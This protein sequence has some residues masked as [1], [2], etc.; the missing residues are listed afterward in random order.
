M[1]YEEARNDLLR[2]INDDHRLLFKNLNKIPKERW[3][4]PAINNWSIKDHLAQVLERQNMVK[5]WYDTGNTGEIPEIPM[6]GYKWNQ[7]DEIYEM[8]YQRYKD[9]KLEEILRL[10]EKSHKSLI[11]IIENEKAENIFTR[12]AYPWLK[13]TYL[14]SFL[15]PNTSGQYW[16]VKT[17]VRKWAKAEGIL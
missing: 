13:N 5:L 14:R 1:N 2:K 11:K 4:E 17:E 6:P 15:S 8:I 7:I 10:F 12:E 9:H 16:W 3:L